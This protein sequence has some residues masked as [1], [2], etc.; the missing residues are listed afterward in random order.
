MINWYE[1]SYALTVEWCLV[2]PPY[3]PS[4]DPRVVSEC[5][6]L[7]TAIDTQFRAEN[8]DLLKR[9]QKETQKY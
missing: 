8:T 3:R 2:F 4:M 9:K 5:P 6:Y 7:I 1:K